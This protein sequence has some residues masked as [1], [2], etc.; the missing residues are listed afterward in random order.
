[1]QE[2][3]IMDLEI[4][5]NESVFVKSKTDGDWMAVRSI[6]LL[7]IGQIFTTEE[8]QKKGE[9]YKITSTISSNDVWPFR[10]KVEIIKG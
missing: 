5:A 7:E 6:V 10:V 1:M 2:D 8:G 4:G 3:R 9:E